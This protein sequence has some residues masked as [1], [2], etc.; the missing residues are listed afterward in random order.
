MNETLKPNTNKENLSKSDDL[1]QIVSNTEWRIVDVFDS[2]MLS[3]I[4]SSFVVIYEFFGSVLDVSEASVDLKKFVD[5]S[6]DISK[7]C[8]PWSVDLDEDEIQNIF[9]SKIKQTLFML[10]QLEVQLEV[11]NK[12]K[13]SLSEKIQTLMEKE[14]NINSMSSQDLH[15]YDSQTLNDLYKNTL[16]Y[17]RERIVFDK[18]KLKTNNEEILKVYNNILNTINLYKTNFQA[19]LIDRINHLLQSES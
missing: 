4:I 5:Q 1:N 16:R 6:S 17:W 10:E 8:K 7:I 2:K 9:L 15:N 18:N 12:D 3:Y 13:W 19:D 11:E 14:S